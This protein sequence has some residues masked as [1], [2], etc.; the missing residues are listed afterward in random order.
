[1]ENI[2]TF[3]EQNYI[4][5]LIIIGVLLMTLI[6]YIADKNGIGKKK[7]KD[8]NKNNTI[9]VNKEV[10]AIPNIEDAKNLEID[11]FKDI[12]EY[13]EEA[14]D[15]EQQKIVEEPTV[16]EQ[17]EN[18]E[19]EMEENIEQTVND[20]QVEEIENNVENKINN[21]DFEDFEN[22]EESNVSFE[23]VEV[24][25]VNLTSNLDIENDFNRLLDDVE[26]SSDVISYELPKIES[27]D[28]TEL[29]EEDDIWKF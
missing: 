5:V 21:F 11:E 14:I 20:V 12:K 10:V 13:N 17:V 15:F 18:T 25:D 7:K 28:S 23:K 16:F 22:N 6:G 1:M 29:S 24:P 3:V 4:W 8:D 19:N 2:M 9:E 26:E 27:F